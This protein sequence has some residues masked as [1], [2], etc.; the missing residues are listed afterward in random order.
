MD[1]HGIGP[2]G[3]ARILADA[4][5]V[6]RFPNRDHFVRIRSRLVAAAAAV[7]AGLAAGSAAAVG[8]GVRRSAGRPGR[9]A[10]GS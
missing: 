7:T 5:D 10:Q 3:A 4:G 2:A 9:S 6:A 8:A 1:I